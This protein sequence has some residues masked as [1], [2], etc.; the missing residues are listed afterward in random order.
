MKVRVR[1]AESD[2][3]LEEV[4]RLF[5]EFVVWHE[6]RQGQ[7]I[8]LVSAYFDD[9]AWQAELAGLPGEYAAQ[10]GGAL[11]LATLD[12][13]AVGCV[14]LRQFDDESAEMKRMYVDDGGRGHGVGRALGEAVIQRARDLDYSAMYLDTSTRAARGDR[15]LP[16]PRVR[17]DRALP[18]PAGRDAGLARVLPKGAVTRMVACGSPGRR[19]PRTPSSTATIAWAAARRARTDSGSSNSDAAASRRI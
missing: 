1:D 18:R 19:Q 8:G 2:A 17:G 5:R 7:N 3:D 6:A 15:A 10:E 16:Q 13:A 11:L 12:G 4:R 9:A 14:A